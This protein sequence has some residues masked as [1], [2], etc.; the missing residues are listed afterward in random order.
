[1]NVGLPLA[2]CDH[3]HASGYEKNHRETESASNGACL[4]RQNDVG[5]ENATGNGNAGTAT[6]CDAAEMKTRKGETNREKSLV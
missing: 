6:S 3:G 5:S 1:M 4:A 2:A